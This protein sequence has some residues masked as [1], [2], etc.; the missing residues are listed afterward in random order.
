VLMVE[1]LFLLEGL[2]E[3]KKYRFQVNRV[4]K[5]NF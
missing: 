2:K 3:E 4:T 5:N 1:M